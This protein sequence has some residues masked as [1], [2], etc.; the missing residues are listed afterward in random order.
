MEKPKRKT[1]SKITPEELK[2]IKKRIRAH[3]FCK[4]VHEAMA[5]L[6]TPFL[7]DIAQIENEHK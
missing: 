7:D 2:K 4:A 3:K 6:M 5:E 1:N